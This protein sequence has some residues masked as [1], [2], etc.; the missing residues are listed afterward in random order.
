MHAAGKVEVVNMSLIHESTVVMVNLHVKAGLSMI[1]FI[2]AQVAHL[3]DV[4]HVYIDFV[5]IFTIIV[6]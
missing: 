4:V 6:A 2:N 5:L 1:I 3:V